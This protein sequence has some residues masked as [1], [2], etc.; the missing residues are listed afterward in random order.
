MKKNWHSA[1]IIAALHRKKLTL[2]AVSRQAGLSSSTLANA[3]TRPWPRGEKLIADA[4]GVEPQEIW[5]VRYFD[6]RG[7]PIIRH[8]RKNCP[9]TTP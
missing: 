6:E 5:P 8:I 9:P 3:L 7:T 2:A 1:D 4:L